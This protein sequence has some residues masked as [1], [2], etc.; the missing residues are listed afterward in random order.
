MQVSAVTVTGK[1]DDKTRQA[2]ID[3]FSGISKIHGALLN[4]RIIPVLCKASFQIDPA[5]QNNISIK[6]INP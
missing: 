4:G 5:D 6:L 3:V 2:F 1:C